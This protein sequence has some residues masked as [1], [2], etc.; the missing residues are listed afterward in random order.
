MK[1]RT[2][3]A[4]LFVLLL[5]AAQLQAQTASQ[6]DK[7]RVIP[8]LG[9]PAYDPTA[10]KEFKSTE[11]GFAISMPGKPELRVSTIPIGNLEI[12]M[13]S[14]GLQ[15]QAGEFGANYYDFPRRDDP[16]VRAKIDDPAMVSQIIDAS[17]DELFARGARRISETDVKLDGVVGRELIIEHMGMI[18][19]HWLFFVHGR[20]F[21]LTFAAP[22]Q[23]ALKDGKTSAT[24][25]D[26]ADLYEEIRKKFFGSFK[27]TEWTRPSTP[28]ADVLSAANPKDE[29]YRADA[30]AKAEIAEAIKRASAEHRRVLL[31]FGANW[32]YDC[33]VLDQALHQ[34]E[35]G[36]IVSD[37]YLLVHVDIG[38]GAQNSEIV[39][40]YKIPL[41]KGVP[42]VAVLDADGKLLYS[43]GEGEFEAARSMLKKD[44]V[45]FLIRWK[46]LER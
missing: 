26:R 34:G 5:A 25:T 30:D 14:S 43:S 23:V 45:K 24:A 38:E 41:D 17:R 8:V 19:S 15:T 46:P 33:H 11:G 42:A 3:V 1:P 13:H 35:A 37:K 7:V 20:F 32:C 4:I 10:W 36:K 27:I 2:F 29:V 39:K 28:A 16:A 18:G 44:L 22:P 21:V 12:V 31:V 9:V 40:E 6:D